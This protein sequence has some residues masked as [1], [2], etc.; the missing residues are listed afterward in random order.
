MTLQKFQAS[1][2]IDFKAYDLVDAKEY[3]AFILN[4]HLSP[5]PSV[6][7]FNIE[8]TKKNVTT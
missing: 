4:E 8:Q 5:E 1:V 6:L 3:I 7:E 2:T